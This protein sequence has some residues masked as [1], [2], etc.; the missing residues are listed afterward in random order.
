M[1]QR[2]ME[3]IKYPSWIDEVG[4]YVGALRQI[5]NY[6]K[7][8]SNPKFDRKHLN[9]SRNQLGLKGELIYALHL[10]RKNQE[11][12]MPVIWGGYAITSYD[13]QVKGLNIDVKTTEGK[14]LH[15]NKDE[16]ENKKKAIEKFEG[17]HTNM[18]TLI[19]I[20]KIPYESQ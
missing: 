4:E 3:I 11:Y 2:Q 20:W 6:N 18:K 15:V 5:S 7:T 9:N 13:F 17:R 12:K 14:K 19:S 10:E 8:I 16:H 1:K